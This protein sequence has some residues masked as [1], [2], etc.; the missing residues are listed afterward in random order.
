MSR[1]FITLLLVI[2]LAGCDNQP[3]DSITIA[4]RLWGNAAETEAI[5]KILSRFEIDHRVK[6]NLNHD[7]DRLSNKCWSSTSQPAK[8]G[9]GSPD[10][11]IVYGPWLERCLQYKNFIP[12]SDVSK[13]LTS[14]K[15]RNRLPFFD[16]SDIREIFVPVGFDMWPL[17][18]NVRSESFLPDDADVN[19][20]TWDDLQAWVSAVSE[21]RY[22]KRPETIY[23]ISPTVSSTLLHQMHAIV[24]SHGGNYYDYQSPAARAGI[25][26]LAAI[27]SLNKQNRSLGLDGNG[28]KL[29][30][31]TSWVAIENSHGL[32][33]DMI[34]NPNLVDVVSVPKSEKTPISTISGVYGIGIPC[35][36]GTT[37]KCDPDSDKL[38]LVTK[39]VEFLVS[40]EVQLEIAYTAGTLP[41]TIGAGDLLSA[42]EGYREELLRK[43]LEIATRS[44]LVS[45]PILDEDEKRKMK[46]RSYEILELLSGEGN[47]YD[48]V[49]D[50]KSRLEKI[51]D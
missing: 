34:S 22:A 18:F 40:P 27:L 24:L 38:R 47:S 31:G 48:W 44:D 37:S 20:L 51:G 25:N 8:N 28:G 30:K 12:I 15:F 17:A 29:F 13:K 14:T 35:D 45:P 7:Y 9:A 4:S 33:R 3:V 39:L 41:S 6:V 36:A 2:Y 26:R 46:E 11:L 32:I 16:K 43:M 21:S 49:T 10:L 19:N 50:A 1:Y 42:R 5:N 23:G